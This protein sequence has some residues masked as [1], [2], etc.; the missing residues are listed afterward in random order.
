MSCP[1]IERAH[2][3]PAASPGWNMHT[4]VLRHHLVGHVDSAMIVPG[5]GTAER[6]SFIMR[7]DCWSA[8]LR[9]QHDRAYVSSCD[10]LSHVGDGLR[11]ILRKDMLCQDADP[12]CDRPSPAE[13]ASRW[14]VRYKIR[15]ARQ[16]CDMTPHTR[17]ISSA[18]IW[19]PTHSL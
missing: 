11:V 17:V 14:M 18:V 16:R 2:M 1:G 3:R 5:K 4:I 13:H 15:P 7:T 12:S 6:F 19:Q 8:D 10:S 9:V